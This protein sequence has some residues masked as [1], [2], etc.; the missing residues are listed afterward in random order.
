MLQT[1]KM[2]EPFTFSLTKEEKKQN[3]KKGENGAKGEKRT[4]RRVW[5]INFGISERGMGSAKKESDLKRKKKKNC[6]QRMGEIR[7]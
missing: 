6:G 4:G 2:K 3:W 1:K 7:F 5:T